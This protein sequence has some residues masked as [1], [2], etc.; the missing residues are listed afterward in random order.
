MLQ[1]VSKNPK[2][3]SRREFDR[4][5]P[6]ERA[7]LMRRGCAL[8]DEPETKAPVVLRVGEMRREDFERLP[9]RERSAKMRAGLRL[10]D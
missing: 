2:R 9:P 4:L 5:G 6:A 8:F 7:A 10:V 1:S 3:M